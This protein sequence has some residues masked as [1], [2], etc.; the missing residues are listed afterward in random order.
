[1]LVRII[2]QR[3]C[4]KRRKWFFFWLQSTWHTS[5]KW[6]CW[7]KICNCLDQWDWCWMLVILLTLGDGPCELRLQVQT[8]NPVLSLCLLG[9][10]IQYAGMSTWS[11]QPL[12]L[13]LTPSS[14]FSITVPT[15]T[16]LMKGQKMRHQDSTWWCTP[17]LPWRRIPSLIGKG[18]PLGHMLGQCKWWFCWSI[19]FLFQYGDKNLEK[20]Y[21]QIDIV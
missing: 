18:G 20:F 4:V 3:H 8:H 10:N 1:M 12:M 9:F 6:S 2:N 14:W 5:E 21:L 13:A 17:P 16:S 7:A 19:V 15:S 11:K